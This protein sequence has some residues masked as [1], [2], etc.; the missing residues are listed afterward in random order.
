[1]V[2][3]KRAGWLLLALALAGA[4][5][6]VSSAAVLDH[7][8][9]AG[10]ASD[11]PCQWATPASCCNDVATKAPAALTPPPAA[12]APW[13]S[14]SLP[15]RRERRHAEARAPLSDVLALSTIVLRL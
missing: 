15:P 11:V 12:P 14:A 1:M 9:P 4:V 2:S 3:S 10:A 6:T 5:L 13:V 8:C 7:C